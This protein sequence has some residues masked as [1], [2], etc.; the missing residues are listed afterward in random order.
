MEKAKFKLTSLILSTVI[1]LTSFF[2][3]PSAGIDANADSGNSKTVKAGKT[4]GSVNIAVRT[5][6]GKVAKFKVNVR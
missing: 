6:F 4:A 3:T 1:V 5:K 2:S